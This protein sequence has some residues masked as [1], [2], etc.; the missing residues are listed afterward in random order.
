MLVLLMAA[1][2]GAGAGIC[3]G[4]AQWFILRR[5]AER[6]ARSVLIHVPAWALAMTAIFFGASLPTIEWSASSIAFT[7]ATGGLSGGILL[8]AVT[9]IVARDLFNPGLTNSDGLSA[10]KSAR[11]P[12]RTRASGRKWR[13]V[14]HASAPRVCSSVADPR[15]ANVSGSSFSRNSRTPKYSS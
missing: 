2:A 12:E 11:S 15:K 14:W 9:G 3:F 13:S 10:E 1:L 4:A 5:H 7:G 8:G 6:A